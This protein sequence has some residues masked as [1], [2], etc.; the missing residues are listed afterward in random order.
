MPRAILL[1]LLATHPLFAGLARYS[2]L[3]VADSSMTPTRP[4]SV[5]ITYLGT[6][7]YQFETQGHSLLVDPYFSRIG[8]ARSGLGWPIRP[9]ELETDN[10]IARLSSHPDAIVVTHG[11]FDHLLDVPLI[12]QRTDARLIGSRAA[13]ELA[14]HA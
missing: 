4:K 1:L 13:V 14:S 5:R 10:G 12:M 11:H 3:I 8:L 6:N 2:D 9:N 7:G